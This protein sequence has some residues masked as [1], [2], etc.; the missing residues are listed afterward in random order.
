LVSSSSI[1]GRHRQSNLS[2]RFMRCSGAR[3]SVSDGTRQRRRRTD[4]SFCSRCP[5]LPPVARWR[6]AADRGETGVGLAREAWRYE[7]AGPQP[8]AQGRQVPRSARRWPLDSHHT[9]DRYRAESGVPPPSSV[10]LSDRERRREART[11]PPFWCRPMPL[12]V[13]EGGAQSWVFCVSYQRVGNLRLCSVMPMC[14]G[15]ARTELQSGN[16]KLLW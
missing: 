7:Q 2:T 12:D 5:L 6:L 16:C 13:D 11:E 14:V 8:G 10:T 15:W 1:T 3:R 4:T 9:C